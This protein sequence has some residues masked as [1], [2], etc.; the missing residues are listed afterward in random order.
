MTDEEFDAFLAT[1]NAEL[2]DKQSRLM[3]VYG[4]G[5]MKRWRFEQVTE[6]LQFFDANDKLALL[7][8]VIDIGSYSPKSK[9]WKWAW[10]NPS[11]LPGLRK[12]ALL[13]RELESV[14]GFDLFG[15]ESAFVINGEAMA[16]ELVA[17]STQ[18]LDAIGCYRSPSSSLDG[19]ISYL[20]IMELSRAC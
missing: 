18:H 5:E 4:L 13:L 14:T 8:K 15:M 9:T 6:Q 7:A 17:V 2:R 10:G 16:W 12:K 19:P 11:V 3:Q 1:A 20:A